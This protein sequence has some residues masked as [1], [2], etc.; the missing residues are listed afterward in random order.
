[1]VSFYSNLVS[2]V[3]V[4]ANRTDFIKKQIVLSISYWGATIGD[5]FTIAIGS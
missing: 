5:C 2:I 3:A 4:T 1:M